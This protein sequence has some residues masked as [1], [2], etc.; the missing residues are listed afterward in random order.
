[1]ISFHDQQELRSFAKRIG[2]DDVT[3]GAAGAGASTVLEKIST[4]DGVD[5]SN[6]VRSGTSVAAPHVAG[7][8][9]LALSARA[10]QT[11]EPQFNS[12]EIRT[13]LINSLRHFS[14]VWN[15]RTGFGELEA[16]QFFGHL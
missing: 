13:T 10:K 15:E 6:T 16:A 4:G 8:I 11:G 14:P 9:A 3:A 2:L 5:S 1:M 12:N 7:V